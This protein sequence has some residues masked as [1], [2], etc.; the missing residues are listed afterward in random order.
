MEKDPPIILVTGAAGQIGSELTP[1]LRKI[2]GSDNIIATDIKT[3]V[4]AELRDSG[5]YEI[6]D[7]TDKTRI[8]KIIQQ[9]HISR[10]Y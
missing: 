5:P 3:I 9:N 4:S 10:I 8:Y 6:L 2:F 1:E 7:V